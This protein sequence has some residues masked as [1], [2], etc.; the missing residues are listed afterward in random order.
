MSLSVPVR[1][2]SLRLLIRP[3]IFVAMNQHQA[4]PQVSHP[5]PSDSRLPAARRRSAHV[6]ASSPPPATVLIEGIACIRPKKVL[7][8]GIVYLAMAVLSHHMTREFAPA[9]PS[10][11]SIHLGR[12]GLSAT[13]A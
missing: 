3:Q 10:Q 2:G 6:E 7:E 9:L 5:S 4:S 11:G 1:G 8:A 13:F 12:R